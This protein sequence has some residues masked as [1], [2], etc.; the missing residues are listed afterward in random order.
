M[1]LGAPP[2]SGWPRMTSQRPSRRQL[3]EQRGLAHQCTANDRPSFWHTRLATATSSPC[4][5]SS[6]PLPV[7]GMAAGSAQKVN[8]LGLSSAAQEETTEHTES[9]ETRE[10]N[11]SADAEAGRGNTGIP[12]L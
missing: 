2:S 9:T 5:A 12:F 7:R 11:S 6:V 8:V 10:E 3:R 1:S 4:G